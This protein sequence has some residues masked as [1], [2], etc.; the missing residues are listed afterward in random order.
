MSRI[1]AAIEK[2]ARGAARLSF[3]PLTEASD[4]FLRFLGV[5][6]TVAGVDVTEATALGI[7]PY[8]ACAR[9]IAEDVASLPLPVYRQLHPGKARAPEHP[10][11]E[12]LQSEPNPEMQA[13]S[14]REAVT[15][16]A[17]TWGNGY[18]EIER[19][20]AG[21]IKHLWPLRPDRMQLERRDGQLFYLYTVGGVTYTLRPHQ[22]L[23]VHGISFDGIVGYSVARTAAQSLGLTAALEE[24]AARLFAN[25]AAPRGVL[26][27]PDGKKPLT[28][29]AI[30]RLRTQ[31]DE[32]YGGLSNAHRVA[33]LEEGVG[34]EAVGMPPEET[35]MLESRQFQAVEI[36]RWFR[37]QPHKI[38]I[39]DRATWANIEHQN[40]EHGTDTIRPWCVRWEQAIAARCFTAR[41]R[42]EYHAEH[43]I[44]A[45]LRGDSKTR[46]ENYTSGI[47]NG[48][49]SPND[50]AEL[51]NRN[52][53][54]DGDTYFVPLNLVPLSVAAAQKPE[55]P[56]ALS[57]GRVRAAYKPALEA[58]WRELGQEERRRV[59]PAARAVADASDAETEI[60]AVI[61]GEIEALA[62]WGVRRVAVPALAFV[63]ALGATGAGDI[64][65]QVVAGEV[66]RHAHDMAEALIAR[67]GDGADALGAVFASWHPDAEA[68]QL[69]DAL[70]TDVLEA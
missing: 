15:S 14:F 16:H 34:Y 35:Q 12:L 63:E 53:I 3:G 38:G 59:V 40:I 49:Y 33:I 19:D 66:R 29:D 17:V 57:T 50:V 70:I 41:E 43:V 37:M 24:Y 10:L 1:R 39:L 47:N 55:A 62:D 69:I 44:D 64:T 51:E 30:K 25:G 54:P 67:A 60:A 58:A 61:A 26:S 18:A 23:H 11:Y 32:T 65:Q 52:P 48:Y 42:E 5:Q 21:R 28:D 9:V 31:W 56:A 22:V 4:E 13:M 46:H 36:C 27:R 2:R 8:W 7:S 68:D 6:Q 20:N 45:L